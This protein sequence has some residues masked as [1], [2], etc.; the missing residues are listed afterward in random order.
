M[1]I[2]GIGGAVAQQA[3]QA[4]QNIGGAVLNQQLKTE[5]QP[6]LS[7]LQADQSASKAPTE[8]GVGQNLDISA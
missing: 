7:I 1:D 3:A 6:A 4:Q 2:S 8:A 5:S